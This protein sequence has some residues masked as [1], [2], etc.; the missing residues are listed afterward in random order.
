MRA[1]LARRDI[2]A[3][4]RLLRR[5]GM[6]QRAIAA[7]TGQSQSEVSDI[8]GQK[9]RVL[10]YDLLARIAEGLEIPPGWLGLAYDDETAK[11]VGA[12]AGPEG[13]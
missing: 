3:V 11:L 10:S 12:D 5:F 7:K 1:A 6:S 2:V 13:D 8:L 4:Y 9:R